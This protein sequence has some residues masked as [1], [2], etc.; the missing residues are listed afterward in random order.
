MSQKKLVRDQLKRKTKKEFAK[1]LTKDGFE[2][3][4]RSGAIH[5]YRHPDGRYVTIHYHAHET[6]ENFPHV[7][8]RILHITGWKEKDFRRLKLIKK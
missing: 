3:V 8:D 2:F 6:F 1:A 7:L 4:V 5:G